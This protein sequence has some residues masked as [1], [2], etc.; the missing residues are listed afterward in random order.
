MIETLWAI[1]KDAVYKEPQA[2]TIT[3]LRQRVELEWKKI[4]PHLLAKLAETFR[5]RVDAVIA[6]EGRKV[7]C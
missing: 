3:Q 2:V 1:L 4:E 7:V 5:K 6:C